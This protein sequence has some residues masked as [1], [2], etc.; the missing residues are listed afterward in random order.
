MRLV[1]LPGLHGSADLFEA[2]VSHLPSDLLPTPVSYPP[3]VS[4]YAELL[5]FVRASFPRRERFLLL[6]E[7]FS[8]PLAVNVAAEPPAELAGLVFAGSFACSP[9]PAALSSLRGLVRSPAVRSTP[10]PL[11]R[12]FLLGPDPPDGLDAKVRRTIDAVSPGVLA[13][14]IRE[15]LK[16]DVRERLARVRVPVLYLAGT[17]DRLVRKSC[18]EPIRSAVRKFRQVDLEAPH[19]LL[20]TSPAAAARAISEFARAVGAG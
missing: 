6:A 4:A 16:V 15:V 2:L 19:L 9:L 1:L 7:S 3:G 18:A 13:A 11:V 5:P 20:Q 12:H 10:W 14:R 17:R 8:G